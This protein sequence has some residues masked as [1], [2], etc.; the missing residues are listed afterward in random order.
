MKLTLTD[1]R[2]LLRC[3]L[4]Y[5]LIISLLLLISTF[6]RESLANKALSDTFISIVKKTKA[7]V[8]NIH[9]TRI[10]R[11]DTQNRGFRIKGQGSGVIYNKKGCIV[12]NKHVV[13]DADEIIIR[14]YD[15]SEYKAEIVGT[16]E[17]SGIAVL[18]IDADNLIPASFGN[19]DSLELGEIV[20][21]IGNSLGLGQ[22]ITSGIISAKGTSNMQ[23]TG[24]E[25]FIQTDAII[26]PDS[27]GGPLVN[28]KGEVV[29][30]SAIPPEQKAGYFRM[31]LAVPINV[32]KKATE[33]LI[34]YGKIIRG[35]LGVNAQPVTRELQKALGLKNNL[36]ALVSGIEPGSSAAN[37]GIKSGDVII[38]Y[39]GKK[40][41]D[42]LHLR[43]LV[44]GTAINKEVEMIVIRDGQELTL[45]T[46]ILKT[47]KTDTKSKEE[48][49]NN[50]GMKAQN[51]TDKLS[52][53]LGYKGEKGAIITKI[54]NGSPAFKAGLQKGDLIIE[55]QNKPVT[56]IDELYQAILKIQNEED[57]LMFIKRPDKTSKFIVLKQKKDV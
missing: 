56:S 37:A 50:L 33:D 39:D 20:L 32:V 55:V 21:A 12:T 7:S 42:I 29:G 9:T 57:I 35:W 11:N 40:I 1:F 22:M 3:S 51:L 16:D 13:T 2:F 47:P 14:L 46:V 8:V 54:Q 30:I 25:D 10:L 18:R 49:F 5:F 44:K 23:L 38:K 31:G 15:G 28:L 17:R 6:S 43:S 41:K 4:S 53:S 26:N 48:L 45:N 24:F 27:Y 36:G 34:K 52:I 19:S